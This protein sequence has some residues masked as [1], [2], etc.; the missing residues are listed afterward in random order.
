M[1]GALRSSESQTGVSTLGILIVCTPCTE[2]NRKPDLLLTSITLGQVQVPCSTQIYM[3]W[4]PG[5]CTSCGFA[6]AFLFDIYF[7]FGISFVLFTSMIRYKC[8]SCRLGECDTECRLFVFR[9]VTR[10]NRIATHVHIVEGR[11]ACGTK[12]RLLH[13]LKG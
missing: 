4:G 7:L 10:P 8:P 12:S 1:P 3:L 5:L 6:F 13:H 2:G 9:I 11:F